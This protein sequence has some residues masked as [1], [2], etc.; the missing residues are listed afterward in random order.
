M[1]PALR[2][3]LESAVPHYEQVR[4]QIAAAVSAGAIRAG[5]RLP[6]VRVLAADLGI[7]S[8]TIARAYRELEAGGIVTTRRRHGTIV[9]DRGSTPGPGVSEAA[10]R[11]VAAARAERLTDQDVLDLVSG[12][13]LAHPQPADGSRS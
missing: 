9:S 12:A 3:S 1:T 13:L 6:T 5:D 11:L 10:L 8:G 2:V 4:A 7:A